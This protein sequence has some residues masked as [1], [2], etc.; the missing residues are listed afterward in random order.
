MRPSSSVAELTGINV[1][2][3]NLLRHSGARAQHAN[4]ES[5]RANR[6]CIWIPGSL[7]RRSAVAKLRI[8]D[9]DLG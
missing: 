3:A 5:T 8:I 4:P 7:L 6:T 9:T 2:A 1:F